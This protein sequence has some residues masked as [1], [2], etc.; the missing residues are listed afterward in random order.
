[1]IGKELTDN[2][3]PQR[4]LWK[5]PHGV[6][7]DSSTIQCASD[8]SNSEYPDYHFNDF[9][10]MSCPYNHGRC[11]YNI[12]SDPCEWYDVSQKHPEVA[13]KLWGKLLEYNSTQKTPLNLIYGTN[14][15]AADPGELDGFWGPWIQQYP[16]MLSKYKEEWQYLDESPLDLWSQKLDKN[17]QR[18]NLQV[19]QGQIASMINERSSSLSWSIVTLIAIAMAAI[20]VLSM[21]LFITWRGYGMGSYK[22][23]EDANRTETMQYAVA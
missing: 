18:H 15:T 8:E 1:V 7:P 22:Q 11:L 21:Y 14:V 3:Y 2:L 6:N 12:D 20:A 5:V 13:D 10:K 9:L 16:S 19:N 17:K 4:S 23:I